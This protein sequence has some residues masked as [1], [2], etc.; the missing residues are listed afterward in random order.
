MIHRAVT[1]TARAISPDSCHVAISYNGIAVS[2]GG[3]PP[4]FLAV[5]ELHYNAAVQSRV[6]ALLE[7]VRRGELPLNDALAELNKLVAETPRHS[8]ATAAF[9]LGVAAASLAWLLGADLGA[10]TVAGLSTSLGLAARQQLGRLHF[11]LLSLPLTA[12]FIGAT[13]GGIAIRL[14]WTESPGLVVIVPALM[15]VPGPHLINGVFDLIDNHLPMSMSRLGLAGGILVSSAMG[16]A[17]GIALTLPAPYF[18]EQNAANHDRLNLLSDM[19]L[20]G[21]ASCGFAIFYNTPWKEAGMAVAGGMAGHG[22]RF[23]ALKSGCQLEAAT[24]LGALLVGAVSA[25][26]GRSGTTPFAVVAFA[27]AVTMMPGLQMYRTLGGAMQLARLAADVE[28]ALIA[29]TLSQAFQGCLVVGA[30]ALGL[31]L[32]SRL[33]ELLTVRR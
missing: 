30:L 22:L 15:L 12:A 31:I 26:M 4:L 14:G 6:H 29:S 1:A 32:G 11:S 5:R 28:F 3:D 8:R 10:S 23:L 2:L 16:V 17:F 33:M 7:R 21:C 13:L 9:I 19:V 27:G 18:P 25:W 24:F 20:A